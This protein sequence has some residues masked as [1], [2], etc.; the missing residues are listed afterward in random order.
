MD[1]IED[2]AT[3]NVSRKAWAYYYSAS[4]DKVS[5]RLNTEVYRSIMLRP[6]VFV[7]CT[8]CD[9]DTNILGHKL[10]MPIFISPAAMARLAHPAGEAGIAEAC[11]SFG[12][13]QVIS[14]NA[15]MTPEQIVKGAAPNQVFG[16]QL[17]AQ[18]DRT[19]SE[20]MLARINK[21][22]AIKFIV[23]T[24]DAPVP[25][26]REDDERSSNVG[27]STPVASGQKAADQ[28]G[29]DD[30]PD[31]DNASG[32]VGKTLF[33]G[34]DPSLTWKET[35]PWLAKH[36][37]LPIILKGLQTHEDAYIASLHT[38]QVKGIILSNHGGRALDTAP[39]AIHTLLEIRKYCPEVLDKLDV[40]V[41]GGIR[42]GTDIVKALCLGAKAVGIGRP[43]LW[44]LG[45]GGV[46][47]VKRT[48]QS[49]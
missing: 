19:K 23:L 8:R 48:L 20:A 39:P 17:Y 36:T 3:K 49:K 4:D 40:W 29:A 7:D 44:G 26:K 35:L 32:G 28:A 25:G 16:W 10:G 14:N 2:V 38:P 27:V 18:V 21:L 15:S 41:D 33:A 13:I 42:R 46:D 9:L 11:R 37:D 34:T 47:G 43:A 5:K 22:K 31:V 12:A 6:R 24:L 1:E 45:A 30:T